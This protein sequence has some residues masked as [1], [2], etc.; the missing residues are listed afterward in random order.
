[1]GREEQGF[2]RG[3]KV[4]RERNEPCTAAQGL[5]WFPIRELWPQIKRKGEGDTLDAE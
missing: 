4:S 2:E 5:N 1:M 3:K